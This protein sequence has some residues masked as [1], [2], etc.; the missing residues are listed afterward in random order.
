MSARRYGAGRDRGEAQRTM[1]VSQRCRLADNSPDVTVDRARADVFMRSVSFK[2]SVNTSVG[3]PQECGFPEER[4]R[5]S[6]VESTYEG[7]TC[8]LRRTGK[9]VR[10]AVPVLQAPWQEILICPRGGNATATGWRCRH[11]SVGRDQMPRRIF[12]N[13][14]SPNRRASSK[15]C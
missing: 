7:G 3:A 11:R 6:L 5:A 14:Q 15:R 10:R 13:C 4:R 9:A 2:P 12:A 1:G 8:G